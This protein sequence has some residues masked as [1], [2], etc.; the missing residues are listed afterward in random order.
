MLTK[1]AT[2]LSKFQISQSTRNA[3]FQ[4]GTAEVELK[5]GEK[6]KLTT[7]CAMTTRCSAQVLFVDYQNM[8]K[9][10]KPGAHVYIDDGLISLQVDSIGRS[11]SFGSDVI[12]SSDL[13]QTNS[14]QKL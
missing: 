4:L 11:C 9:V 8:P 13:S 14:G 5:K 12:I 6:I 7:N 2:Y 3:T 10:L 1:L